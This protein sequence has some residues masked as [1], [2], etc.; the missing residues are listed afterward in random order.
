MEYDPILATAEN[1]QCRDLT[2][3]KKEWRI[4][5]K[6]GHWAKIQRTTLKPIPNRHNFYLYSKDLTW[7]AATKRKPIF[8]CSTPAFEF[9][10]P[11]GAIRAL[12]HILKTNFTP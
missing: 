4:A 8:S 1:V 6:S 3:D 5:F 7:T 2:D 10:S 11:S 9:E 12:Y